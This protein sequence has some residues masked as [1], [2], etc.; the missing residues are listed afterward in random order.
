[1]RYSVHIN[2]RFTAWLGLALSA[3]VMAAC[4]STTP[5]LA[6]MEGAGRA[7]H[8]GSEELKITVRP[9]M[10]EG[11]RSEDYEFFGVGL[12][13][14]FSAFYVE[15]HNGL[16]SLVQ[17]NASEV[18]LQYDGLEPQRALG[19]EESIQYYRFRGQPRPAVVLVPKSRRLEKQEIA[20][21]KSHR[22][23]SATIPP[24]ASHSGAWPTSRRF[25][26]ETVKR[27]VL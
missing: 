5:L 27:S 25:S 20:G 15:I 1:M 6:P 24:N 9:V 23:R 7:P 17:I 14:F 2:G 18:Y 16:P 21:I 4:A 11:F 8:P 10:T 19:E 3:C 26:K 22:L 13:S 12:S